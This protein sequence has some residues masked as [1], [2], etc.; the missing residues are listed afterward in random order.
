MFHNI[1]PNYQYFLFSCYLL[2]NNSFVNDDCRPFLHP[3]KN[4]LYNYS[5]DYS[6]LDINLRAL[7]SFLLSSGLTTFC[8]QVLQIYGCN[9]A[10]PGCDLVTG[11]PRGPC[12]Q[13]CVTY[14]Q[15]GE[16]S[17]VVVELTRLTDGT[18]LQFEANCS[19]TLQFLERDFNEN[20]M[21]N[22]SNC[23]S[24]EGRL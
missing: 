22:D 13:D 17:D 11:Q 6:N 10:Y 2:T 4:Y 9:Y 7:N 3:Q 21:Y 14:T 20:F 23:V 16:C 19:Y 15:K 24:I 8:V 12:Q 18:L 5:I 1:I